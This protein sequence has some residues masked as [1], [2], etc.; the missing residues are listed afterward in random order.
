[1][2]KVAITGNIGTGKTTVA[3]IFESLGVPIFY[4]DFQA[5]L[6]YKDEKI[7]R[8]ITTQFGENI[9]NGSG[10]IDFGL[11]SKMIFSDS[12]NLEIINNI[13]HPLVFERFD[14]WAGLHSTA[15]Y[16][17]L[18]SAIIFESP[19]EYLFDKI[20]TVC[21]T[22]EIC[23]ERTVNRDKISKDEFESKYKSQLNQNFKIDHSDF[24]INNDGRSSLIEQ[25]TEIHS[26][27]YLV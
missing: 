25:V 24:I 21:S 14:K 15:K 13:I 3:R 12:K 4:S 5:K 23:E 10:E 18:E 20:I 19:V 6:L 2:L 7:K 26:K 9:L 1:M 17:I 8:I 16:V 27:L 11:L 22:Y